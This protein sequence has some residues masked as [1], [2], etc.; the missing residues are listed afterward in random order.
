M[1]DNNK[2]TISDI[3]ILLKDINFSEQDISTA[4]EIMSHLDKKK[5]EINRK[6]DDEE[7]KKR[8]LDF[9]QY[10]GKMFYSKLE[11]YFKKSAFYTLIKVVGCDDF[12]SSF[13]NFN[14]KKIEAIIRDDKLERIEIKNDT[15]SLD[16]LKNYKNE[17][18][19]SDEFMQFIQD[20]LHISFIKNF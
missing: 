7:A 1:S 5:K 15:I 2:Q 14:V 20:W 19:S 9:Q 8:E 11:I 13:N 3:L 18:K 10:I 17:V 6:K 4:N 16:F 12:S